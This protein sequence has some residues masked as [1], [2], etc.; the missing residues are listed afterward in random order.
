VELKILVTGGAGFIGMNYT[1]YILNKYP[2]YKVI[3][4][5][6]LL[7][8]SNL[9]NLANASG[10][11]RFKFVY[12]SI[13]DKEL[14][15]LVVKNEAPDYIVNFAAESHVDRS[16]ENPTSFIETNINGTFNLL[17]L[18]R[19]YN[20]K[21][22]HQVSTDE[23]YGDVPIDSVMRFSENSNLK[24]SSPYSAS[25]AAADL[26]C[27]SYHRTFNTNVTLSRSSNNYGPGQYPEKLIPVAINCLINDKKI[28]VYGNGE[29][30]RD[31]IHV[32][33]HCCAIDL[34]VEKGINGEVYN[35]SSGNEKS[36]LGIIKDLINLSGGNEKNIK[37][38]SDRPGH[39]KK[40]S[41]NSEKIRNQLGWH[42]IMDYNIGLKETF[43]YYVNLNNDLMNK[44]EVHRIKIKEELKLINHDYQSYVLKLLHI[45]ESLR[46][47]HLLNNQ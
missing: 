7:I 16:I 30:V 19:K 28:P 8:G 46:T 12:G 29:N 14:L 31:W 38:V 18:T 34:I 41:V 35:V 9:Y 11:P 21:R 5:D 24:P 23:V 33:D 36:N 13:L 47:K 22:F 26:L 37:H 39:D 17:E 25:K 4:Y 40:Y 43:E 6:F 20:V 42:P 2:S 1:T 27:L 44:I 15:D 3:V 10:N 45:L 32:Y